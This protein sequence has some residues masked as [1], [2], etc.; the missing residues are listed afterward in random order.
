MSGFMD[1]TGEADGEPKKVG[2]AISDLFTGLYGAIAIEAALIDARAQRAA[3][4][5][6][7]SRCSTRW[8]RC[9]PTRR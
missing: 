1:I 3:A 6:S 2:V 4:S 7:T 9:S 5:R 8:A